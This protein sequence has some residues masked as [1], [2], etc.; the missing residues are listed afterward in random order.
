MIT[1]FL[2]QPTEYQMIS[3]CSLQSV[4]WLLPIFKLYAKNLSK[5]LD[6]L[7]SSGFSKWKCMK[8]CITFKLFR[9]KRFLK[10]EAS[11]PYKIR[12]KPFQNRIQFLT[13]IRQFHEII[14]KLIYICRMQSWQILNE[15]SFYLGIFCGPNA[16]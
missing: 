11:H 15:K 16:Y 2:P 7:V 14:R 13:H 8:N 9:T 12:W 10:K 1:I 6:T 4:P 5:S 3:I